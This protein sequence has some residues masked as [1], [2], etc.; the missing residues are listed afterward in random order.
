VAGLK[1]RTM[2][3]IEEAVE[4]LIDCWDMD[5]LVNYAYDDMLHYFL[6]NADQEE[7]RILIEEFG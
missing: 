7:I 4:N 1:D 3:A 5:A 2:T 6:H